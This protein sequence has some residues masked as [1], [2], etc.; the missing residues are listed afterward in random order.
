[1]GRD[2]GAP[3]PDGLHD[4][5]MGT[6]IDFEG[7]GEILHVTAAP[8]PG[9]RVFELDPDYG[10]VNDETYTRLPTSYVINRYGFTPGKVAL[11]FD[12]GPDPV[13]TPQILDILKLSR[14]CAADPG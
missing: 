4:I 12:D 8:T 6:D 9:S 14:A 11:T 7:R 2:Y 10:D 5:A 1:M 3:A 13:W